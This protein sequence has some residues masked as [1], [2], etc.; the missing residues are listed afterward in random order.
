MST[1]LQKE[2]VAVGII[3]T[4]GRREDETRITAKVYE[5]MKEAVKKVLESR[6]AVR[7]VSG[8]A[9]VA[10]HLAVQLFLEGCGTTLRL[11]LPCAFDMAKGA[12]VDTGVFDWKTNPGGTANHYHRNFSRRCQ[13]DSLAEIKAAIER[14][15]EVVVTPG[16]MARNTKVAT[17]SEVLVA[18]TFGDKA[19]LKDG[20]TADTMRKFL[21][22]KT[23]ESVHIDCNT[24]LAYSPARV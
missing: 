17:E 24:L 9:A 3:G 7:L 23:G 5:Q 1:E 13:I 19:V 21:A 6:G 20:G 4:A 18:L 11:H 22:R 16:F 14:G 2:G 15:A 10:D 12:F 8:G